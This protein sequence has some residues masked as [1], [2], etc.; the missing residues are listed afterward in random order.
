MI[1]TIIDYGLSNLLSVKRAFEYVGVSAVITSEPQDVLKAQRL[2]LPG[3]GAFA[4]G[5]KGLKSKGLFEA[6][7]SKAND[8]TPLLGICLGMQMLLSE[9]EEFGLHKGLD[10]IKGRIVKLPDKDVDSNRQIVPN[11]GWSRLIE[12]NDCFKDTALRAFPKNAEAYFVHSFEAKPDDDNDIAATVCYGGREVC[13]A[14]KNKNGN[15][16]GCQ[17]H[18]EKSGEAGITII[19]EFAR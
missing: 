6:I 7:I 15:V 1:I 3:V 4:D 16:L 12:K 10:I 17:F 11:V 19:K 5:I 14:V 13:A 9:S 2:V 18:P 8:G